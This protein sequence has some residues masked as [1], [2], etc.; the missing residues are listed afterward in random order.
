MT[1]HVNGRGVVPPGL[2]KVGDE[3]RKRGQSEG[4]VCFT[5]AQVAA[6]GDRYLD[7]RSAVTPAEPF[8]RSGSGP[9]GD[10]R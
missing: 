7:S 2:P 3:A 1:G 6:Q 5:I 8:R 4:E 10:G 9:R